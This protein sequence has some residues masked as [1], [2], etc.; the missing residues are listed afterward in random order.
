MQSISLK[1]YIISKRQPWGLTHNSLNI[2][3]VYLLTLKSLSL[4]SA[5]VVRYLL[6][7]GIAFNSCPGGNIEIVRYF[8]LLKKNRANI[9]DRNGG[10][11]GI[12]PY[13]V[14]CEIPLSS[15]SFFQLPSLNADFS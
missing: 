8:K 6:L 11:F 12:R 2:V 1:L 15:S 10:F 5:Q 7:Q 14:W 4:V 3:H 13:S 9:I